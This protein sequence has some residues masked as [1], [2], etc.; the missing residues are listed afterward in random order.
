VDQRAWQERTEEE[1][2]VGCTIWEKRINNTHT[3]THTH[4]F[5]IS[6]C[7]HFWAV[8]GTLP[9]IVIP[10]H[11]LFSVPLSHLNHVQGTSQKGQKYIESQSISWQTFELFLHSNCEECFCFVLVWFGFWFC[12]MFLFF[13]TGFLCIALAVLELTL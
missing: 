9:S 4:T 2:W 6:H 12:F 13:E 7:Q 10:E 5:Y 8:F 11:F 3:H 1:L